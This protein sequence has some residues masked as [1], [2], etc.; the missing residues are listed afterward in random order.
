MR[1]FAAYLLLTTYY[2]LLTTY[3]LL[4]LGTVEQVRAFAA[5]AAC[6]VVVR[7]VELGS[8]SRC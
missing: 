8:A 2:L 1:A 3:Y 5:D 7:F 6:P 4:R